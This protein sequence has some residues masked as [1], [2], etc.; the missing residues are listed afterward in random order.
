MRRAQVS[1]LLVALC[2]ALLATGPVFAQSLER[3][4]ASGDRAE[5]DGSAPEVGPVP[6][7]DTEPSM[8]LEPDSPGANP[9]D[10]QA[11]EE[12]PTLE[13]APTGKPGPDASPLGVPPAPI[14]VAIGD[15]PSGK[16][17]TIFFDATVVNP[18]PNGVSA[19]AQ[20]GIVGGSNF[21]GFPTDDPDDATGDTDPTATAVLA[22]PILVGA[23]KAVSDVPFGDGD[24]SAQ[25]GEIL[26]YTISVT[27]SGNG[28][29]SNVNINDVLPPELSLDLGSVSV[30]LGGGSAGPADASAGNVVDVTVTS[31]PGLGGSVTVTF[32]AT[33]GATI[34]AALEV[35]SNTAQIQ[36][37]KTPLFDTTTADIPL[38]AVP[39]F[40]LVKD[41]GGVNVDPGTSV[42][43]TLTYTNNGD[44]DASN[45]VLEDTVPVGTTFDAG[46]ST[47]GWSCADGDPAGTVCTLAVGTVAGGGGTASVDFAAEVVPPQ[48]APPLISNSATVRDDGAGSGGVPVEASDSDTTEVNDLLPPTVTNVDTIKG[49]GDG[50]LEECESV[51]NNVLA[52]T[53]EFSEQMVEA[54]VIDA[55][56]WLVVGAGADL[57]LST[58]AC[59]P[60]SGDDVA[61]P[62]DTISYDAVDVTARVELGTTPWL[63]DGP[64]RLIAC[65]GAGGIEDLAGNE[66]DGDG[67]FTGGDDF[68]RYFRVDRI[69]AFANGHFD[70]GLDDWTPVVGEGG[71]SVTHD[72]LMDLDDAAI[73]GSA[74][75][76]NQAGTTDLALGQCLE[77][78]G[79][80]VHEFSGYV[81]LDTPGTSIEVIR[82]CEF[83]ATTDCSG[84]GV[85]PQAFFDTVTAEG[86][87]TFFDGT[88]T[89]PMTA[90]SALCQTLLQNELGT[91]YE[92][93]VDDLSFDRLQS[94]IIFED[95]FESGD[96]SAWDTTVP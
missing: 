9:V 11:R 40:T 19:V 69:D 33:V 63:D 5:I 84:L 80:A 95:G 81:F 35:L 82:T 65:S 92:A 52:F 86:V 59:G 64:Y 43:Y 88:V 3:G 91:Q 4:S 76:D 78:G 61:I 85:P 66:L 31:V 83:F 53:V 62:I 23:T 75:F 10:R 50:T 74:Y 28:G 57:D 25:P 22:S 26:T 18:F 15:L 67:D 16:S 13:I 46:A 12:L 39:D 27:N 49:S 2:G 24:G 79:G 30:V 20:Q 87:W 96:T 56:N 93:F 1:W 8:T 94:P 77:V 29:D 54:T 14:N 51:A 21:A 73:S 44:Q 70:C 37:P 72:P 42:I 17:V 47:A 89:V 45:V 36:S 38:D 48:D 34:P 90:R 68:V 32:N 58:D 6:P 41:D 60:L 7:Q 55:A 71:S